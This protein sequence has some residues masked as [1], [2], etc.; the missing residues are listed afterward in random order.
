MKAPLIATLLFSLTAC[1]ALIRPNFTPEFVELRPGQY[2]LDKQHS[3]INFRIGHLG[4][5]KIVGRFNNID[6]TLD[7][8]PATPET[9]VLNGVIA[10][11]S[12]DLNNDD[13]ESTLQ[14]ASWFDSERYPQLT[15]K[16]ESVT[17]ITDNQL[18]ITGTLSMRGVSIPITLNTTFNGGADN[19]ITRKYTIGFSANATISRS[20]FGMDTFSAFAS[21]EIEVEMHGEFLRN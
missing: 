9:L 5:S 18:E 19:I 10:A 21:D 12:I 15:F 7:F 4:L 13:F 2:Q 8:D 17:A 11:D 1:T 20:D 16:S 14:E 3:F 6:A